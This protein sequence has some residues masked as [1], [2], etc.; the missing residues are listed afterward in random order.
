MFAES[1]P[2]EL[3]PDPAL[4]SVDSCLSVSRTW[5]ASAWN[6]SGFGKFSNGLKTGGM[7]DSQCW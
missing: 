1:E 3:V 5:S 6:S 2:D 4:P 7:T